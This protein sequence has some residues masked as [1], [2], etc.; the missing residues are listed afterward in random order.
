MS[1][2]M[3]DSFGDL[4]RAVG[5]LDLVPEMIWREVGVPECHL[6]VGMT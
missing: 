6:Q 5:L 2:V 4:R 3:S 1:D